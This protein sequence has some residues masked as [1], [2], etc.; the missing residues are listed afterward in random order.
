MSR[1]LIHQL[2]PSQP[3]SMPALNHSTRRNGVYYFRMPIPRELKRAGVCFEEKGKKMKHEIKFSLHVS[4]YN[5]AKSQVA[6]HAAIWSANFDARLRELA[7][8]KEREGLKPLATGDIRPASTG[9]APIVTDERIQ[10]ILIREFVRMQKD[11]AQAVEAL[12]SA[13]K[14]D[15]AEVLSDL[16]M[17]IRGYENDREGESGI[18]GILRGMLAAYGLESLPIESKEFQS[19]LSG[20]RAALTEDLYRRYFWIAN[21][22]PTERDPMFNGIHAGS[23]PPDTAVQM[24]LAELRV[25]F[26]KGQ[27]S[28][29]VAEKTHRANKVAFRALFEHFGESFPI[30]KIDRQKMT[31]FFDFLDTIPSHAEQRYKGKS[32]KE[33]VALEHK[34][35]APRLMTHRTKA[36][37]HGRVVTIFEYAKELEIIEKNPAITKTLQARFH[38][39]KKSNRPPFT[40]EEMNAIF[41]APLFTGCE[42]DGKRWDKPGPNFPRRGRFWMPLIAMFNGLRSGEASQLEIPDVLTVE[43]IPCFNVTNESDDEEGVGK[44]KSTKTETSKTAVPIHPRLLAMG[45]LDFVQSR[46]IAGD[47]SALFPELPR[48]RE[49]KRS[50]LFSKWFRRFFTKALGGRKS[51]ASFHSFRHSFRDATRRARMHVEIADKL[52]R[53]AT[54]GSV[55]LT[56]GG[57]F[58]LADFRDE[59]AKVDYPGVDLSHLMPKPSRVRTPVHIAP[60]YPRA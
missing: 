7:E 2:G 20:Y 37:Y 25:V 4:D 23:I 57:G 43:G 38:V 10:A 49:G 39:E 48:T 22:T 47:G 56:Y 36:N 60:G 21:G 6:L 44:G 45:F 32:L 19:L 55:G 8:A 46:K 11:T 14:E 52:G 31:E 13:D 1:K 51:K 33:A 42:N 58:T 26:E 30:K 17:E 27:K 15:K 29:R 50:D 34:Q 16:G 54:L 18:V 40:V 24:T 3:E 9:P 12:R 5:S 59:L 35:K 28:K 41:K 53:W